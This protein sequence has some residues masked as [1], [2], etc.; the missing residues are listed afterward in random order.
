MRLALNRTRSSSLMPIPGLYRSISVVYMRCAERYCRNC[1][2]WA[3]WLAKDD[4]GVEEEVE[5]EEEEEEEDGEVEEGEEN[6]W[7]R[8]C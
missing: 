7:R 8:R 3:V 4:D 6:C 1:S 2:A 5:D